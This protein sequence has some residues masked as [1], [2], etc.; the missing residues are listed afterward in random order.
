MQP[1]RRARTHGCKSQQLQP[2][3][4]I[5]LP[6]TSSY[7]PDSR[8]GISQSSPISLTS[9]SGVCL[10]W[11]RCSQA[12][13][14]YSLSRISIV[15][16]S[17][18]SQ[19]ILSI[20][21]EEKG[22]KVT[23]LATGTSSSENEVGRKLLLLS[24]SSEKASP[25]ESSIWLSDRKNILNTHEFQD[26]LLEY[27]QAPIFIR[28]PKENIVTPSTATPQKG[29]SEV[30]ATPTIDLSKKQQKV[31]L[32]KGKKVVMDPAAIACGFMVIHEKF[33]SDDLVT[34][35]EEAPTEDILAHLDELISQLTL[36]YSRAYVVGFKDLGLLKKQNLAFQEGLKKEKL[37]V[38]A[39]EN[40]VKNLGKARDQAEERAKNSEEQ[41]KK[42]KEG[43]TSLTRNRETE[44]ENA[45]K[46]YD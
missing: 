16:K 45:K 30:A 24:Y 21:L 27:S 38:V 29:K 31:D 22:P 1:L 6:L 41:T 14:V 39:K 20:S 33:V 17:A 25:L 28:K 34:K 2:R 40:E 19:T 12:D 18:S 44:K 26:E 32:P 46:A 23:A 5:E 4:R 15:P 35:V 13:T 42:L 9:T 7:S 43:N 10:E 11:I 36:V 8:L 37:Y 3:E